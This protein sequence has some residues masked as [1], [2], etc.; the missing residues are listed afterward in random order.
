LATGNPAAARIPGGQGDHRIGGQQ[1]TD[2]ATIRATASPPAQEVYDA[3]H[4]PEVTWC[5][6]DEN[7][8]EL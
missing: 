5:L 2:A 4:A 1:Q 7:P 8:A 6:P 3:G